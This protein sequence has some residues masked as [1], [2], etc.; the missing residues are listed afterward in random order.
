MLLSLAYTWKRTPSTVTAPDEI[1]KSPVPVPV[2]V[3]FR[4]GAGRARGA[5]GALVGYPD[6]LGE[7]AGGSHPFWRS[8][9]ERVEVAVRCSSACTA[10]VRILLGA[11]SALR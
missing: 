7:V 9:Q 10:F 6:S 1:V 3:I 8:D 11:S 4:K 5:E 2:P